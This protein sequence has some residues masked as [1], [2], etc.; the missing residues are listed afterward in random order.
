MLRAPL[1]YHF[2]RAGVGN[3]CAVA[4]SGRIR[5]ETV[6]IPLAKVQSLRAAQGP[7]QRSL[8]LASVHLDVAGR[9]S[10][11]TLRDR[12]SEE[13]VRLLGELPS[14]CALARENERRT[15]PA[16]APAPASAPALMLGDAHLPVG[17]DRPPPDA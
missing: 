5:R 8:G 3:S 9:R 17:A 11:A 15:W 14:R 4:A 16:A 7:I 13:A 12:Q 6:W 10:R 1:S 2:L